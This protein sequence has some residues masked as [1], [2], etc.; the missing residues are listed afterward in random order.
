MQVTFSTYHQ[1]TFRQSLLKGLFKRGKLPTVKKGLYGGDLT[2][3]TVTDEHIIP[4]SKGGSSRPGNIA[5]ATEKNNGGRGNDP[6]K[7][8][9]TEE[10]AEEYLE[11]FRDVEVPEEN[12]DG[13]SY[14]RKAWWS[15][16]YALG[17]K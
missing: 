17:M 13:N 7:Q 3:E 10:Q 14:I 5:L 11:Q 2:P 16:Q 12:F 6:L 4:R 15:I 8:H 9:L 1:P